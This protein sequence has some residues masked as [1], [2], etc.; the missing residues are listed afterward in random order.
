LAQ[1][2][3]TTDEFEAMLSAQDRRCYICRMRQGKK[4]LSVDHDHATGEV[5]GLLCQPCNRYI[6]RL[7]DDPVLGQ[8]L[9]TY[10]TDPPARAVLTPR[11]WSEY[12]G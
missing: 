8:R 3:L 6:G 7:K 9:V 2:G 12:A 5:R 4:H 10:L 1:Y 11:D